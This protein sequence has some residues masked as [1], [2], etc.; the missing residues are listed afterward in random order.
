MRKAVLQVVLLLAFVPILAQDGLFH[1]K[2]L[3]VNNGL[4]S[5]QVKTIYKDSRGYIWIGTVNGLNRFDGFTSKVFRKIKG[6]S[7][8]LPDNT[9]NKI[10]EDHTGK[11]WLMTTSGLTIFDPVSEKFSTDHPVFHKNIFI[12]RE[13]FIDIFTDNDHNLWLVHRQTGLYKYDVQKDSVFHAAC[14]KELAP[15]DISDISI[16]SEGNFWILNRGVSIEIFNPKKFKVVNRYSTVLGQLPA[17]SNDYQL[18]VDEQKQAWIFMVNDDKGVYRFNTNTLNI[19][20]YSSKSQKNHLSHDNI[21]NI[22]TDQN[23]NVLIGTDHGGL[24]VVNIKTGEIS[25]YE[26]EIGDKNSLSQ[27]SITSMMRDD[28]NIIWIGTYKKGVNFYHPD[29]FKF[30][31]YTLNSSRK[32]WLSNEDVNSFAEDTK[33]NLW[34]GTNGGGLVYFDRVKNT[35]KTFKHDPGNPNS[36]SSDVIVDLCMDHKGG[37]WIGTYIGG[38]NYFDGNRFTH[39]VNDPTNLRSL[40]NNSIWSICEDRDHKLWIGT[41]GDGISLFDPEN[42]TFSRFSPYSTS[43]N[44]NFIMSIS[45][46]LDKNIW[47]ATSNGVM[48]YEKQTGRFIQYTRDEKSLN[49]LSSNSTL[50]IFCDSRGWVWIAS[51]EGINMYNPLNKKFLTLGEENGILDN[52]ILTILEANDGNMWLATPRGLTNLIVEA[53][54][55]GKMVFT[56][57]N[58]DEKDGLHGKEFNEH[59][60]YKTK[61]G[62]LIFGGSDGFS[63]FNPANLS[64]SLLNPKVVFSALKVQNKEVEIGAEINHRVLLPKSL[65]NLETITL[66]YFEKTFAISFAALNYI[67]PEKT[68]FHYKLDGF[69][70]DWTTIDASG[71]EVTYTNLHPGEYKFRVYASDFENSLQSDEIGLSI[72]VLPPFWKTK[73]AYS[74]YLIVV[75][76][77]IFYTIQ[78]I[79]SRERNK[80]LRHQEKLETMKVHEMDLMKLKFFTNI[81]HEFRTPLTLILAPL[82]RLI[83]SS[84]NNSS[85][86]QLKLIQRN[87][88][89]LLNLVNQLLDFR[90]LEVQGLSLDVRSGEL[91]SFCKDATESFSDLSETRNIKL[92]FSSNINELNAAFDYD[93][94]E[95]IIFNLLS[96]AFKFTNENGSISVSLLFED[97]ETIENFVHLVV[98][99]N[100]IGI[101]EEKQ[102]II[103]ERF[104]QNIPSGTMVNKGSG[105]GLSL[106]REFVQMHN[107]KIKLESVPGVGSKFTVILPVKGQAEQQ[108][109]VEEVINAPLNPTIDETTDAEPRSNQDSKLCKLLLVEDNPDIRFYLKDNLKS[110]YKITEADNGWK[111]WNAILE[112]MPDLVVS[113]IM[114]PEMDG[115]ELCTKIKSDKRTSHIPVI[116][117]TART[118]DQQKYEGLETGADDYITKPFN[119]EMLELRIQKL[120]EQRQQL[121]N[122]YSKNFEIKPSEINVTSLDEKF[123]QKV[124]DLT[125][126]NMQE[127]DFSVEKLSLEIGI[128]RAHL[129]NKLLALTGKTPIEYI[130]IMRIRRAAQLLEKSQLTV[131]EV[132]YKVGFNDPRYFTKHFKHEYNMTPS[133]YIKKHIQPT[134]QS[135]L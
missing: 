60:A 113:D 80:F 73:W 9:V 100:G 58:Y 78:T 25:I 69:N 44:S 3:D 1:F 66:R 115:I 108:G 93:K 52:N 135:L 111:A 48:E 65:N 120:I 15:Y 16:G 112:N 126:K 5:N 114:M 79:I 91:V 90:R 63:I 102:E 99:D 6:D 18:M 32:N 28:N 11:L 105:I 19:T 22:I 26:N 81:S 62:E 64:S 45:E 116:L 61:N 51:R 21:S 36:L 96:N 97:T 82:D 67:N 53:D 70:D 87:G 72:V 123:L 134:E 7:T 85:K 129:Y 121:R 57:R 98:E 101:P 46:N 43:N 38:L 95:K 27:N 56:T 86:E 103:F 104:V 42:K 2:H 107:G 49:T 31:A 23:G 35:F 40:P 54:S 55:L 71:R 8:S 88:K 12:P 92:S 30:N 84:E 14:S 74:T 75:L 10:Y 94:I 59:A 17:S 41:L 122:L 119:F 83:K 24:N 39:Y 4:S 110:N 124:K 20:H 77:I 76:L 47:F 127:P 132:A 37:L 128:S 29:L 34:I 89:R 133:Q 130:R 131:M 125:E 33:G 68:N 106:T 13:N 117:L 118:T 50:D 109:Y